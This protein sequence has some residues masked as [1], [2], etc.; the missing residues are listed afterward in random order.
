MAVRKYVQ[1]NPIE[2]ALNLQSLAKDYHNYVSTYGSEP[3]IS[4]FHLPSNLP[5][6]IVSYF[7]RVIDNFKLRPD[8][9]HIT[10]KYNL[11]LTLVENGLN[12]LHLKKIIPCRDGPR[13]EEMTLQ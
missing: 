7:N 1:I 5:E 10:S 13:L 2:L 6:D 9:N 8:L 12:L 4:E 11:E 3:P